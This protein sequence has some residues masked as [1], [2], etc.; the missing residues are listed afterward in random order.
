[1]KFIEVLYNAL[2][3]RG[4]WY[5]DAKYYAQDKTGR[6][7]AYGDEP[8]LRNTYYVSSTFLG[9]LSNTD[10]L[11]TKS[12]DWNTQII[13]KEQF[14]K[15]KEEKQCDFGCLPKKLYE[16]FSKRSGW[17]NK[18]NYYTFDVNGKIKGH[19]AYPQL[20]PLVVSK[21]EYDNFV[22]MNTRSVQ[23]LS[24]DPVR[25]DDGIVIGYC[26]VKNGTKFFRDNVYGLM[27]TIEEAISALNELK[28]KGSQ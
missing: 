14:E 13:S 23:T 1:M 16:E 5:E 15:Y 2:S 22:I 28:T 10:F 21:D 12:S 26:I 8:T 17:N 4:G 11:S 19:E 18:F 25:N 9:Y 7:T 20:S 3:K 24:I 27:S 6:I